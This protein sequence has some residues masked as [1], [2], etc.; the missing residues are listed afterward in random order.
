MKK[1][2]F[3][4]WVKKHKLMFD[5]TTICFDLKEV[6]VEHDVNGIGYWTY[7]FDEVIIMQYIGSEDL[8]NKEVFEDDLIR[9]KYYHEDGKKVEGIAKIYFDNG[10]YFLEDVKTKHKY[11]MYLASLSFEIKGNIYQNKDLLK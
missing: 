7:S 9:Y 3:R 10:C 1:N 2:K 11:P 5:V 8:N 6:V 4:V